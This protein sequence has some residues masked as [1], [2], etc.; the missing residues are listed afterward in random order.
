MRM[1][2]KNDKPVEPSAAMDSDKSAESKA[3]Q[4][5]GPA[6]DPTGHAVRDSRNEQVKARLAEELG[7]LHFMSHAQ[8]LERTHPRTWPERLRAL[9]NKELEIP[10]APGGALVAMALLVFGWYQSDAPKPHNAL[11]SKRQLVESGGS[12]YWKDQL[13]KVA[14]PSAEETE[15]G[16]EQEASQL[17]L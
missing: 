7:E 4:G 10:V 13:D 9:W 16:E 12:T 15:A 6:I 1:S 17:K 2:D 14:P 3:S 5:S 8:V 11:W